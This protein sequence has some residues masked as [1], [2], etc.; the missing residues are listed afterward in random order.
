[1]YNATFNAE[2]G[3]GPVLQSLTTNL[4]DIVWE[5]DDDNERP[6]YPDFG[7]IILDAAKFTGRCVIFYRLRNVVVGEKRSCSIA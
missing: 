6:T 1:M 7:L 2:E 3:G 4:V 5:A